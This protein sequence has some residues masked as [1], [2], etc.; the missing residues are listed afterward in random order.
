[1]QQVQQCAIFMDNHDMPDLLV[2]EALKESPMVPAKPVI[3]PAC[4]QDRIVKTALMAGSD[5][6]RTNID[7]QSILH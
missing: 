6:M 2:Y 5:E 7:C 1:M 3:I 4:Y